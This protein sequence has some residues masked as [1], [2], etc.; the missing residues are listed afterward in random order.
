MSPEPTP[1]NPKRAELKP[2]E[3]S[4]FSHV[5]HWLYAGWERLRRGWFRWAHLNQERPWFLFVLATVVALDGVMV[6][7][8]GD[9]LVALAVLS[10]PSAWRRIAVYCGLGGAI[11]AFCL[12][13]LLH[14]FGKAPLRQLQDLTGG[15][16]S[17]SL[18]ELNARAPDLDAGLVAVTQDHAP[19][20][21]KFKAFFAR[22]G[23]FSLALG[24]LL[25]LFSWPVVILAGLT[26][27]R[28][29]E[30]LFWLVVGRQARYWLGCFGL[31]EGWAMFQALREEAQAHKRPAP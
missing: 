8:P 14:Q 25:P 22:Y 11:G 4:V 5:S 29:W 30:V 28:W 10:N 2:L 20:W 7:L 15:G 19:R 24:S 12:Y 18:S 31:R 3:R 9:V 13:L 16:E 6:L 17:S 27:D 21:H 26:T 1:P 23:L